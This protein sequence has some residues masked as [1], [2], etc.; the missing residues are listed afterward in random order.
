[1]QKP[2]NHTPKNIFLS[3]LICLLFFTACITSSKNN[4]SPSVNLTATPTTTEVA[5]EVTFKVTASDP[6]GDQLTISWDFGDGKTEQGQTERKHTYQS[7]DIYTVK[8]IVSDGKGGTVTDTIEITVNP[9][10]NAPEVTLA[11]DKTSGI[12]PLTIN[13]TADAS[14]VDNDNLTFSWDFGDSE[15]LSTQATEEQKK[16]SYTYNKVGTYIAKVTV[17]DDKGNSA[18]DSIEITTQSVPQNKPPT[19][20]LSATPKSGEAALGVKF[21]A[22]AS[23]PDGDTLSYSWDFGDGDTTGNSSNE[24]HVYQKAGT[25]T[26]KVTVFDGKGGSAS[27]SVQIT[28]R[29]AAQ[30]KPPTVSLS[31]TPTSGEAALGV[32]FI[33]SASDPDGDTLSYSWDFGDGDTTGNSSNEAHVYQKAG[34]FTAKVTV[35]DGKGGSASDSVQ[36]TVREAAQNKPPTVS[37]SATPTSGEAALGVKFIASASD[38]DGDT[39]S[40]SWDFGDGD[41]TGNSSNEAHV[42]QKAGTFTAK[43]TVFDGKGGSASDSVQITVR[44]AAQNKPPTV[45]LSATPTSGEAALGVKFIASASDPDGDTLSYSWDF[46]DGDTTGDSSN[47]SHV[48]QKAGTF[49]AKVTVFDDKGSS[50][51]DS[52]QITVREA[53]RNQPPTV[54]LSATPTSGEA[55]LS[56]E[57]S[58]KA[59]DPDG[60]TLSYSW[61]FGDGDTTGNSSN[62]SHVYQKAGTFTAKVTVFDGKGGSA[63]DSVQITVKE[64]ARNQPPTVSLSATPT[65]GEAALGVKFTA[66]ASDPDGDTLSYS[67]DFGDGDTTGNNSN[68]SHVYQKAGTFT[69]KVTVFDGKGGSASDSVQITVRERSTE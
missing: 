40:Y 6:D 31:A 53:A 14:D 62:E 51:S 67:W 52:V 27:D 39:L 28:V 8:V 17:S 33:A 2:L 38:P 13:F 30:N 3:L 59:T 16:R 1:M 43:V 57:F 69:A 22:S 42:Y 41:T 46:G 24:A 55:A 54:S 68:E 5:V 19:V 50:A 12:V 66:K 34:T 35:F 18:S 63:S 47:E 65:S 48:Y 11:A 7:P 58:A 9:K 60:D 26:A 20:S 56:V 45:S 37:L 36:I 15:T 49:T 32:K 21:I 29:E 4:K 25:F 61:D 23:D 44:E 64:A 10:N